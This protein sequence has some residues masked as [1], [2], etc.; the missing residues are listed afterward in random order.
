MIISS[1]FPVRE[2]RQREKEDKER[3]MRQAEHEDEQ[4][5]KRMKNG[6]ATTSCEASKVGNF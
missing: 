2:Y 1:G 5:E 4:L 6:A 3:L